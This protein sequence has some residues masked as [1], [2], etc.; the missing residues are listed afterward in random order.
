MKGT[1]KFIDTLI[2]EEWLKVLSQIENPT[3]SKQSI[4]VSLQN[5]H[6]NIGTPF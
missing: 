1:E 2:D 4:V 6:E 5:I 3:S